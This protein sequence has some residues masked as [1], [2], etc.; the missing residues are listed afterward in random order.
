MQCCLLNFEAL[1]GQTALFWNLFFCTGLGPCGMAWH[2]LDIVI[3]VQPELACKDKQHEV[4][5]L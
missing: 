3:I 5:Q 4:S 2:T 1:F